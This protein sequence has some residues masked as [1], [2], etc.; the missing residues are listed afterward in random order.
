MGE[1]A[2]RNAGI[3]KPLRHAVDLK[4]TKMKFY[5][6][7]LAGLGVHVAATRGIGHWTAAAGPKISYVNPVKRIQ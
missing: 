2:P 4:I 5:L 3:K 1:V 6:E 7:L